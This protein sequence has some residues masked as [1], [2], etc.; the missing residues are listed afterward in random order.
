MTYWRRDLELL[1]RGEPAIQRP[2]F[3]LF[4]DTFYLYQNSFPAQHSSAFHLRL[5]NGLSG[6]RQALWPPHGTPFSLPNSTTSNQPAV[7]SKT[8]QTPISI[9]K[10]FLTHYLRVPA[11]PTIAS[12]HGVSAPVL[13]RTAIALF[14]TL[15]T[16][17]SHAIFAMLMAGRAWP[18]QS[19][20]IA[21]AL[22]NPLNIAGPTFSA[23]TSVLKID[24]EET[25]EGLLRRVGEQQKQLNKHQHTPIS[26]QAQLNEGDVEVWVEAKRQFC[27]WTPAM[28]GGEREQE[29]GLELVKMDGYEGHDF[30]G[31]IWE[32]GMSDKE[33][34]RVRAQWNRTVFG[35]EEV[36]G[37][38]VVVMRIIG[39]LGQVE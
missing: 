12:H 13:V 4:A 2:H 26:M 33:M 24:P 10:A 35:E 3:K 18:F 30:K 29:S 11:I 39:L 37:F 1:L 14:N 38:L 36:E 32:C 34:V 15:Q 19:P 20:E 6:L 8:L 16:G 22:P 27:N 25:I 28:W 17:Q 21:N 7:D 9:R 31:Y 23:V 5:L